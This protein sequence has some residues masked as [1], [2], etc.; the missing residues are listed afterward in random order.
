MV[1][2]SEPQYCGCV[3]LWGMLKYKPSVLTSFPNSIRTLLSTFCVLIYLV[4]VSLKQK[5]HFYPIISR[6]DHSSSLLEDP[7]YIMLESCESEASLWCVE[8]LPLCTLTLLIG[9]PAC[10]VGRMSCPLAGG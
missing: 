6:A 4:A 10:T 3:S 8:D 2:L 7:V 5:H 9:F 1:A